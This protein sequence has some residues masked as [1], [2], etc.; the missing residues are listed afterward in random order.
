MKPKVG[1]VPTEIAW[2]TEPSDASSWVTVWS[3]WFATQ[4]KVPSAERRLSWNSVSPSARFAS[5]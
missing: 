2:M 4:T 1:L 3:F 5:V